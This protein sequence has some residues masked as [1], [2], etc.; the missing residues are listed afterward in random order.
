MC[1]TGLFV[2]LA[3]LDRNFTDNSLYNKLLS[4]KL[5]V[6]LGYVY[7]NVVA[8]MLKASGNQLFYYTFPKPDSRLNYEIDFLI[9]RNEKVCPLEVKSGNFRSHSSLDAFIQKYHQRLWKAFLL[10]TK[11][12]RTEGEIEILPVYMTGLL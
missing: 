11:D 1:D 12:L 7:E 4:D 2:T 6:D 5:S 8:Q 10:T 3:F 9:T